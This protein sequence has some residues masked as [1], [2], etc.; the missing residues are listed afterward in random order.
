MRRKIWKEIS[1]GLTLDY[2]HSI[3]H[4]LYLLCETTAEFLNNNNKKYSMMS[5]H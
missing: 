1:D 2:Q 4:T 3:S 5:V